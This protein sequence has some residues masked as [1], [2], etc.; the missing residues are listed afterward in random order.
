MR[1]RLWGAAL[2]LLLSALPAPVFAQTPTLAPSETP[3]VTATVTAAVTSSRTPLPP[4]PTAPIDVTRT[5]VIAAGGSTYTV[6][7]GDTLFRVA[8]RYGLTTA[9][10]GAANGITNPNLIY[11]GQTLVIPAKA[12]GTATP[13]ATGTT[14]ATTLVPTLNPIATATPVPPTATATSTPIVPMGTT[15]YTVV[16]GD[17]LYRVAVK[18][19]TTVGELQRLN[20][21][22]NINVIIIGQTLLVPSTPGSTTTPTGTAAPVVPATA[23]VAGTASVRSVDASYGTGIEV[24]LDGSPDVNAMAAQVSQLGMEW[25]KIRVNWR[26]VEATEGTLDLAT[27][28]QA[29]DTFS[30]AGIKVLLTLTGA[31]D[32]A[33]PS[34]TEYVKSLTQYGPPDDMADF[35][36]FAGE[37]ATRYKGK[38]QAYEIWSEPNLRR[39]WISPTVASRE[40]TRMSDARYIDLLS[41]A[42]KAI[43]AADPEAAVITGG[44]APTGFN[45][46]VNAIDDQVFLAALVEQNVSTVA[47]GI[48]VQPDGFANPPDALCCNQTPGVDTHFDNKRFYFLE[49]LQAYDAILAAKKNSLPLWVTRFGW[50]T[51]EGNTLEAPNRSEVPFFGYTSASEQAVYV[52]R[53]FEIGETLGY[54]GPMFLYN[55]NGCQVGSAE[56][57]YYSVI[58]TS[59][60]ARPLF[61]ALQDSSDL[62]PEVVPTATEAAPAATVEV[63]PADLGVPAATQETLPFDDVTPAG[64]AEATNG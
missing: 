11:I 41:A 2:L 27:V 54:V 32:W 29:V 21:L 46:R 17:T 47:D 55:L 20:N 4:T 13:G 24:F 40:A 62:L 45:D 36:A 16:S 18:F 25:V 12:T 35:G 26:T 10:L 38:V 37:I 7:A 14:V 8:L 58:N 51:T 3:T 22:S 31:P 6:V 34:A 49:T 61:A 23:T 39:S 28:D 30:A 33:R 50:G 15:N 44:L 48:G 53:A 5:A 63:D 42:Y 60:E 43:K 57:C 64:T 9:E 56:A 19:K 1:Y 52:P 59:G